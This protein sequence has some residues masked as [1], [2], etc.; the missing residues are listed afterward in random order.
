ME[1]GNRYSMT[2]SV[3]YLGFVVGSYPAMWL[4]QRFPIER[5]ASVIVTLWGVC[6]MLTTACHNYQGIYA[7]RFFLGFL[8]AGISPMFMLIVGGWYKKN[9]QAFRMGWWYACTGYVSI[10]SPVIN[11]G[12][13]HITGSLAPWK[14]MYL[15]AGAITI[16]WGIAINFLLPADPISAK[17]FDD[18]QRYIAVSRLRVNNAGVRNTHFKPSQ[19]IE[20]LTDVKFWLMFFVAFFS[21]FANAPISTFVPIIIHSFGFNTLNSL[22]L[23]MPAGAFA[24]TL[25]LLGPYLS[26]KYSTKGVRSWIYVICQ[27]ITTVAALLLWLLPLSETGALL[28]ACYILPA[29]GGAYAVLMGLYIANVAGYTKRTVASSGLYIGYCLGRL[30]HLFWQ[31]AC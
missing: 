26:Y 16:I 1:T 19:A 18:R 10:F 13:G 22:L 9:E 15:F 25:Q 21:M 8:E 5:V 6:L 17:G 7:Q 14:Y 31:K 4:A 30:T 20:L 28:F 24:G 23:I 27:V 3:F 29:T 12:L 11:Y 2:A